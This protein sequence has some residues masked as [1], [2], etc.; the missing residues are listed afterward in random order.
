[1]YPLRQSQKTP[2]DFRLIFCGV[3]SHLKQFW[4]FSFHITFTVG[5]NTIIFTPI[6]SNSLAHRLI[7]PDLPTND[8]NSCRRGGVNEVY[9]GVSGP[10]VSSCF[11]CAYISWCFLLLLTFKAPAAQ[12]GLMERRI[13]QLS[14]HSPNNRSNDGKD[15]EILFDESIKWCVTRHTRYTWHETSNFGFEN[16]Q[17]Q[18]RWWTYL[19][20]GKHGSISGKTRRF[21]SAGGKEREGG[22]DT[23]RAMTL[24]TW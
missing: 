23:W 11:L 2:T 3:E 5:N 22:E 4:K 18:W 16:I 19:V 12:S 1:M 10:P 6:W 17:I 24:L 21:G 9:S 14:T 15:S 20:Q 7:S 13:H 8:P